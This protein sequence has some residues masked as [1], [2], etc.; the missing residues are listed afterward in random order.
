MTNQALIELDRALVAR[1]HLK[2]GPV[3]MHAHR[4]TDGGSRQDTRLAIVTAPRTC[5]GV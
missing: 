5:D 1:R 2:E 4:H 3:S